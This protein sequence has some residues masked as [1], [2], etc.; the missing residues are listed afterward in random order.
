MTNILK[1]KAACQSIPMLVRDVY[2]GSCLLEP[3]V[4]QWL[5]FGRQQGA[6]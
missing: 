4:F 5:V 6:D 1:G 2:D 3:D